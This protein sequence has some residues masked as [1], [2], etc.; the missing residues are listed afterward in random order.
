MY[1]DIYGYPIVC[2]NVYLFVEHKKTCEVR[3][4]RKGL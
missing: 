3:K 4:R 1:I 2:A